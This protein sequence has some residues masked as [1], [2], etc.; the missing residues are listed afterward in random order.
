MHRSFTSAFAFSVAV[1]CTQSVGLTAEA[2]TEA[3]GD[4]GN[5]PVSSDGSIVA[6]DKNT[7]A[8]VSLSFRGKLDASV[9]ADDSLAEFA[10]ISETHEEFEELLRLPPASGKLGL[11]TIIGADNRVLV[12]PTTTF[13]ARATVL[14]T[15]SGGRCSGWMIGANTVVTAGH[16]VHTGGPG[17]SWHTE[18]VVYPGRNGSSSPYGSCTART[19]YSAAGWTQSS[20]DRYDYGAVKL[21]CSIGNTTGWY[22]FFWTN[23]S[24]LNLPTT[25]NGYP[26]DTQ[27]TQMRSSD[28]VRATDTY[29]VFYEND[30]VEGMSGGP[31][32]YNRS[33][34]PQC[35]MAIHTKGTYN[36]PPFSTHNHGTR[37]TQEVFNNL[38]AWENAP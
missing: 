24:L 18:V 25:I 32:Y 30:T 5:E 22:G 23:A 35:S 15:F 33:G 9:V 12:S 27:L 28:R 29:E 2:T 17:G 14:I 16:C 19:L 11:E 26:E 21:N 6:V 3:F 1:F 13:P 38:L 7:K 4:A 10:A 36:G 34:C 31:V 37:I 8:Q 20:D